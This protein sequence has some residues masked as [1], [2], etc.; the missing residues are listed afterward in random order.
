MNK[1]YLFGFYKRAFIIFALLI[2]VFVVL[3]NLLSNNTSNFTKISIIVLLAVLV[4]GVVEL[5]RYKKTKK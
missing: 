1:R 3:D 2:P 5:I 4:I